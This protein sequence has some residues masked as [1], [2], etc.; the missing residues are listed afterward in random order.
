M[1]T[2]YGAFC[3][4]SWEVYNKFTR[5]KL[6]DSLYH[7]HM[8][9][10]SRHVYFI[11]QLFFI[12]SRTGCLFAAEVVINY[13]YKIKEQIMR[14]KI[15]GLKSRSQKLGAYCQLLINS[16]RKIQNITKMYFECLTIPSI[17]LSRKLNQTLK[18][19]IL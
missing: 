1:L 15:G 2:C 12:L 4:N 19:R 16:D 14:N 8:C 13:T 7:I 10:N 5:K 6:I 11:S 9:L 3:V 17:L 18:E